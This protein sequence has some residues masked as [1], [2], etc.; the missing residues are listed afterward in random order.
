LLGLAASLLACLPL[1]AADPSFTSNASVHDPAIR[2]DGD[3]YYVFGSHLAS[4]STTDLMNWKQLS[5]SVVVGNPLVAD[6]FTEFSEALT[7]AQNSDFWAPDVIKLNDGRYYF[8]YC[9]CKGDSPRSA[10]GVA[11]SDKIAGPY[12]NVSVILKSG[13]WNLASPDGTVYDNAKH[14][15]VVDPMVF[16]DKNGSYWMVYG[17]YSGGIFILQMDPN[18]GLPLANQAYGKKLIGGN[19]STIEGPCIY[20]SPETDYYY[21]MMTYGGLDA[22]GGYNVRMGRSR[23]PDGPYLDPTGKDLTTVAGAVGTYFDNVSIA[24]YGAKL[25]GNWQFLAISSDPTTLSRGYVSPGGVS[26]YRNPETGE[27]LLTFHTRFVGRGEQHEVRI[28]QFFTTEDGWITISPQRYAHE[29]VSTTSAANVP[30]TWK[31]INHGKDITATVKTSTTITLAADGSISG[32]SSGTWA[33]S[34]DHYATLTLDSKTYRGVF[35]QVWDDDQSRWVL[36]FSAL[37]NEGITVWGSK[38]AVTNANTAP[39][40]TTQPATQS[41]HAGQAVTFTVAASGSPA[42]SFQWRRNGVNIAGATSASYTIARSSAS[43]AGAYTVVASNSV[44]SFLSSV[45]TLTVGPAL[46]PT[47]TLQPAAQA[48]TAG[49]SAT[50]SVAAS[51]TGLTYQWRKYDTSGTPQAV[52]G[53]TSATLSLT[54]LSSRE[55]GLYDCIVTLDGGSTYSDAVKVTVTPLQDSNPAARLTNL[56]SRTI[57]QPGSDAQIAGFVIS[58]SGSKQLLVRSSGPALGDFGLT[59]FV[60]DPSMEL[61]NQS[62]VSTSLYA[63]DNWIGPDVNT[64]LSS[65]FKQLGAFDWKTGSKDAA[66]AVTLPSGAYTAKVQPKTTNGIGLVEVYEVSPDGPRLSNISTRSQVGT[67]SG[68]QIAGFV[69]SGTGLKTV[70]IR[71]SGPALAAWLSGTVA[72]PVLRLYE[73]ADPNNP[74]AMN[75]DWGSDADRA[76]LI[77]AAADKAGAFGWASG[78]KDAALLVS[79]RPGIYSAVYSAKSGQGVGLVEIYEINP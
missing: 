56:S 57:V 10:L 12:K 37:S 60:A 69:I 79:L 71:A 28:H 48:V 23:S 45:A 76:A 24:P 46:G 29:A 26:V 15:N 72:D 8:Y 20:Y 66:L 38:A 3:T 19:N 17:S 59:G 32:S 16:F 73:Q 67:D 30:G 68:A 50:L 5:S 14:P 1:R 31:L 53:A 58:G 64:I 6:P 40:F 4:A 47:L 49:G 9:S 65:L 41:I 36:S 13:M 42:P 25:M 54:G 55:E 70:L 27:N 44:T 78:G 77:K 75:D 22:A 74:I 18:T 43:D 35:C 52:A 33:I 61:F 51:G 7:W 39:A 11:V 2:R 21:L 63:N 34:G 62:D